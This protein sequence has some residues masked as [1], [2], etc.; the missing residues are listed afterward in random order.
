M[1]KDLRVGLLAIAA[2]VLVSTWP[3]PGFTTGGPGI[4]EQIAKL[5][6]EI[7]EEKVKYDKDIKNGL[8][9]NTSSEKKT[10]LKRA[11]ERREKMKQK[12]DK[13]KQLQDQLQPQKMEKNR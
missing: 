9:A 3:T 6:K 11:E 5:K 4:P 1:V 10:H 2:A 8:D 13:I 12:Q 7:A